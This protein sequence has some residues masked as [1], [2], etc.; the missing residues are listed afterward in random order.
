M[1]GF[2][3]NDITNIEAGLESNEICRGGRLVL[4]SQ[5]IEFQSPEYRFL[6][7]HWPEL[8]TVTLNQPS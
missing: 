8:Q 4:E 7:R 3:D 1:Q 6:M 2:R 5:I